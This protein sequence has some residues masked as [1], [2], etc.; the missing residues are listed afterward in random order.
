M[1]LTMFPG[2]SALRLIVLTSAM[3][4]LCGC[5]LSG[6]AHG[7]AAPNAAAAIDMGLESYSPAS[8]TIRAGQTV[9]WRNTS[10]ITHTVTD[11][12]ERAKAPADAALPAGAQPFGSGDIP[13]G[14]VYLRRFPVAGTYHYFCTHHETDGMVG[15][16]VV[17]PAS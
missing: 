15:T 7:P 10:L 8:V 13:A 3:A 12:P 16:I 4:T 17:R 5:G 9:E 6:P 11:D 2:S 14:Q 1:N